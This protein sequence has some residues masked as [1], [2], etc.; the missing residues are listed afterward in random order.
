MGAV[1]AEEIL[2]VANPEIRLLSIGE[3]AEKG[4]QLTLEAHRLLSASTDLNS[5]ATPRD[6]TCWPERPMSSSRT[7]S[8]ATSP[9]R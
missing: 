9:S 5:P 2:G 1:F 6:G 7:G 3:E 4:N 8:R